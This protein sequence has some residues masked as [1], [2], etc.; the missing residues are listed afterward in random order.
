MSKE[1]CSTEDGEKIKKQA[2]HHNH[3]HNDDDGH[4]HGSS[5]KTT[6]QMFFPAI[7]SLA[8]L[9]LGI[10]MDHFF[11]QD[12]FKGWVR[13]GLFLAAY[14]P[15]GLPVLKEAFESIIKGDVFS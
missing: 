5:D 13:I 11:P 3:D 15:V 2:I 4:D 8:L 9:L 1:C 6:F 7:I 14:I 10:G 12:W